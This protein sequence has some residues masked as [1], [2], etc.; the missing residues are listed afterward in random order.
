MEW[1]FLSKKELPP[2]NDEP[3]LICITYEL[4]PVCRTTT[5]GEL[6]TAWKIYDYNFERYDLWMPISLPKNLRW[7]RRLKKWIDLTSP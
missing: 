7:S 5:G 2:D 1:K 6:L 4:G 3:L